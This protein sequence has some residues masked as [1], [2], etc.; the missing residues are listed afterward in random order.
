MHWTGLPDKSA[1][2]IGKHVHKMPKICVH[3]GFGQLS[4]NFWTF[5]VSLSTLCHGSSFWAAQRFSRY[6]LMER[7]AKQ[8]APPWCQGERRWG[9]GTSSGS[10][11]GCS[12]APQGSPYHT[13]HYMGMNMG[14]G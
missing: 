7:T 12:V 6:N 9:A 4:D 2:H 13:G 8:A 5:S 14:S 3:R 11:S 10:E 1:D